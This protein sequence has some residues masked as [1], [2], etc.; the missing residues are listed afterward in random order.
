MND[1]PEIASN[2]KGRVLIQITCEPTEKPIAKV[3]EIEEEIV[4]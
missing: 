2:W 4:K 3:E 1:N